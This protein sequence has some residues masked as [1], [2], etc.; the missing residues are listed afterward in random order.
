[1]DGDK[2]ISIRFIQILNRSLPAKKK[3]LKELL[4]EDK[5][6]IKNRDGSTHLFDRKELEKL[7]AMVPEQERGRLRLPLYLEMSASMER[8]SIKISGR[9]ECM[10]IKKILYGDEPSKD[11]YAEDIKDYMII[12]YPHLL[13]IRKELE[14]TTQFMFTI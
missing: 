9:L 5:P 1:M 11:K 7:A 2:D 14:T 10:I 6:S 13:K 8:G 3:T 4:L 12:Y